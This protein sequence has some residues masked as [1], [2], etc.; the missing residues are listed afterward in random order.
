MGTDRLLKQ[1]DYNR[2]T[3]AT[4]VLGYVLERQENS[5]GFGLPAI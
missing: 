3:V 5:C 1:Q 4:L 2:V